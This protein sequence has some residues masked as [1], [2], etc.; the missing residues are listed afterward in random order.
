MCLVM[1]LAFQMMRA[2]SASPKQATPTVRGQTIRKTRWLPTV[3]TGTIGGGTQAPRQ[4]RAQAPTRTTQRT[5]EVSNGNRR[6]DSPMTARDSYPVGNFR[7]AATRWKGTSVV[8]TFLSECSCPKEST[9]K[10]FSRTYHMGLQLTPTAPPPPPPPSSFAPTP[11]APLPSQPL[12]D[13]LVHKV[14][15]SQGAFYFL[16]E[17]ISK[18]VWGS[19]S[20][21]P[22]AYE[23]LHVRLQPLEVA[24]CWTMEGILSKLH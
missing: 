1:C 12:L 16:Y 18:F 13:N 4:A 24:G 9:R 7:N 2:T 3:S 21:N 8:H 5:G 10:T 17:R 23:C 6:R 15:F 19:M 11:A 20:P 14:L 22:S